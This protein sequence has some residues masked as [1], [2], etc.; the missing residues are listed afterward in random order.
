MINASTAGLLA[1]A[2]TGIQVFPK[3]DQA[4]AAGLAQLCDL[5]RQPKVWAGMT[6][7]AMAH[8]VG[9]QQSA[10][11]YAELYRGLIAGT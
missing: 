8:P 4:L 9:W 3:T 7:R 10:A 6:R 11:A 1:K 5:Y 2:A